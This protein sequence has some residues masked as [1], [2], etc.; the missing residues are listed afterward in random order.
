M[1]LDLMKGYHQVK[2]ADE[3]KPKT[4]FTCHIGLFRY[5]RMPFGLTNAPALFQ[6]LMSRLFSGKEWSFRICV[7]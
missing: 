6:C 3:S 4:V 2:V 7:S 5:R 1:S